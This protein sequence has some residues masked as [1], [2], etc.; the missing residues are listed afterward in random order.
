M[1]LMVTGAEVA[2]WIAGPIAVI[3]ALGM[4]VARKAVHSAL[5]LAGTMVCLGVLYAS[6]DAPF[7]F[8]A[9]IIVYTGSVMMLFLFTMM[10]IG[11]DNVDSL[12]ETIRGHRVLSLIAALGV[13]ALL[14]FVVGN[15]VLGDSA[16]LSDANTE[17]GGNTQGLAMLIF[18]RY[19]F[20]F[21]AA[22][23]LVITA[24]LAAMVL[25][26]ADHLKPKERQRDQLERKMREYAATGA[27]MAPLPS[28]GVYARGNSVD[29]PAL[30]PD[31]TVEPTSISKTLADRGL[32]VYDVESLRTPVIQAHL[33]ISAA[34]NEVGDIPAI[35][36][37]DLPPSVAPKQP[38]AELT[39]GDQ[40][41]EAR[42]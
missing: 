8:V 35:P 27:S 19:V 12:K 21:E 30:R 37:P 29:L 17:Y 28:S 20:V 1:I 16:G 2:F 38:A 14:C 39:D 3:L 5:C 41:K 22:A 36:V 4:V 25:A 34:Q 13:G 7:L 40:D 26:H 24:A 23:A 42:K 6:M 18:G 32:A 15:A 33:E 10:L 11:V 31:G 9:Q